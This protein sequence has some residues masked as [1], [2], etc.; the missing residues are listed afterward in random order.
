MCIPI[1]FESKGRHESTSTGSFVFAQLTRVPSSRDL[2]GD[3]NH[4]NPHLTP[5]VLSPSPSVPACLVYVPSPSPPFRSLPIFTPFPALFA[6][7]SP[8]HPIHVHYLRFGADSVCF[9]NFTNFYAKATG[10][11]EAKVQIMHLSKGKQSVQ[12]VSKQTQRHN[13]QRGHATSQRKQCW[14]CVPKSNQ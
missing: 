6:L 4:S 7:L 12:C 8:P 11:V 2:H 14:R 1:Y 9:L 5:Q 13:T 3:G 10:F